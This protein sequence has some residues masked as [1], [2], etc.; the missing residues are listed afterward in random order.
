MLDKNYIDKEFRKINFEKMIEAY[1][2]NKDIINE[3][4]LLNFTGCGLTILNKLRKN[5]LKFEDT[6]EKT[7]FTLHLRI[8]DENCRM[9][10]K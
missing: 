9:I 10:R 3:T 6:D 8:V 5:E 7:L 4:K 2:K 1:N